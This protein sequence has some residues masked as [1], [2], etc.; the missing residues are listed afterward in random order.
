MLRY[1]TLLVV[2]LLSASTGSAQTVTLDDYVWAPACKECHAAEYAAWD[3]T[4]HARTIGRL[5]PA[6]RGG[7]CVSC[8]ST[9]SAQLLEKDVNAN[10]QCEQCHGAGKAHV[11]AA[12]SGTKPGAIVR[13]PAEAVCVG[14]HSSKSPHFKFFSYAAMGPLVHRTK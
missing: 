10:V 12:A 7:A 5:S 11:Q 4:K 13:K 6:D 9:G 1:L 2:V 8:H 14:C 3:A